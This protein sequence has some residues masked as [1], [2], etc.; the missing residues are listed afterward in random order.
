[1]GEKK[2]IFCRE[3]GELIPAIDAFWDYPRGAQAR[4]YC[5]KHYNELKKKRLEE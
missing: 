1:M 3:G 2:L 4:G 5:E